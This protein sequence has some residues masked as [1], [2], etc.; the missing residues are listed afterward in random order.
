[1]MTH[2]VPTALMVHSVATMFG[3]KENEV[4]AILFW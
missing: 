3:N 4:A 1:M 2:A